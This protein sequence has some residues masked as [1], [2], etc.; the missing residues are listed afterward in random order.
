MGDGEFGRER[1]TR[2]RENAFANPAAR[3]PE[4]FPAGSQGTGDNNRRHS[5]RNARGNARE[6]KKRSGGLIPCSHCDAPDIPLS[7]R[8][9]RTGT[10]RFR[11]AV[12]KF[13][14]CPS[15]GTAADG[16]RCTFQVFWQIP[17]KGEIFPFA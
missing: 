1:E 17:I 3:G 14:F 16:T 12:M 8:A 13:E 5:T 4:L 11:S 15:D 6:G 9:S 10:Q 2:D 7:L